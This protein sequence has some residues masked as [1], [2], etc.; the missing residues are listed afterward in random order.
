MFKTMVL[1]SV[2]TGFAITLVACGQSDESK[3][4]ELLMTALPEGKV[5]E[6]MKKQ[7]DQSLKGCVAAS[8][9]SK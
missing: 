1:C 8:K 9:L 5:P 2:A 7:F 6:H 4:R 3:C